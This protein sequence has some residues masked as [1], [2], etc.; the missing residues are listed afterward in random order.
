MPTRRRRFAL[1]KPPCIPLS[2]R[3]FC[4]SPCAYYVIK[5]TKCE[6]FRYLRCFKITAEAAQQI[7]E[8]YCTG[9]EQDPRSRF[10]YK[11]DPEDKGAIIERRFCSKA[12]RHGNGQYK[13]DGFHALNGVIDDTKCYCPQEEECPDKSIQCDRCKHWI[14]GECA[15]IHC[16][17]T[18]KSYTKLTNRTHRFFFQL[19]IEAIA[20]IDKYYCQPCRDRDPDLAATLKVPTASRGGGRPVA[21]NNVITTAKRVGKTTSAKRKKMSVPQKLVPSEETA[22]VN[23]KRRRFPTAVRGDSASRLRDL[24]RQREKAIIQLL[25]RAKQPS[26]I[27]SAR[28]DAA[29]SIYRL[30]QR[31]QALDSVIADLTPERAS[32]SQRA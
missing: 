4:G 7:A 12:Q 29:A 15:N 23:G 32:T 30:E 31:I 6:E 20:R 14:H 25:L 22:Q 3:C 5:C 1:V 28:G 11:V 10:V 13:R 18:L 8:F 9:C 17:K 26:E 27:E 21:S 2:R 24:E 19:T 16:E